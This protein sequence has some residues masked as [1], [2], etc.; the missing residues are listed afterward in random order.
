VDNQWVQ[1]RRSLPAGRRH[2]RKKKTR[3]FVQQAIL[4]N[5][6]KQK[7]DRGACR[8]VQAL[9]FYIRPCFSPQPEQSGVYLNFTELL[10]GG[11]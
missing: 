1:T 4:L 6:L 8:L 10:C 5:P 2:T 7:T 9:R 3:L 11:D